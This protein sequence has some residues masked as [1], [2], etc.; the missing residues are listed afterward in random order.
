MAV[1]AAAIAIVSCSKEETAV[2]ATPIEGGIPVTIN[3]GSPVT[4]TMM[5]GS[6]PYWRDGDILG[7]SDGTSTNVQ[8]AENSIPDGE[9]AATATFSGKVSSAGT[10]YAYY[11]YTNN[12]V[13][14]SGAKVDIP[15]SQYPTATSFD[16]SADIMVSKSF[17][18]STTSATTINNL[19]FARLGAIVKIVLTDSESTMVGTQHPT[20]VSMT[21]AS[22]L[23]GRVYI[24]MVNQTIGEL[25]SGQSMTVTANYTAETKY[26][27]NGSNATYLIVYP[28]T[29]AEGSTLTIA[30]ST[31]DY[32]I[33]KNI[34]VPDGGIT[35]LPGKVNTLNISLKA[36]HITLD[37]SGD[38]LPFN[39]NMAWADNGASDSNTDIS[40]SI[41]SAE[42]S[43][44]LYTAGTKT[45][46]GKGGL[47]LGASSAS[48]SITTKELNLSGAFYI[49]I[50]SG[51]YGS[52]TGN[53]VV[54]VDGTNVISSG[55]MTGINNVNIAAGTFTKK[56]KVTIATSAKRGYLYSVN[57]VSG[58]H[59]QDPTLLVEPSPVNI[60]EGNTQQL[61]VTGTDGTIHYSSNNNSV[62]TVSSTGLVTAVAAGSTTISITSDATAN[63]NAGSTSVTINVTSAGPKTLPYQN[64]LISS[65]TD[66]SF[67]VVSAGGLGSIWSDSS[68]GMQ[69]NAYGCSSSV[70]AYAESPEIDLTSVAGAK[71]SFTHGINYFADVATAKTQ[72]TLEVKVKDGSWGA[73]TIPTYPASLGNSTANA[74]VDLS[75]YAGSIIQFRFKYLATTTNPGRW[76]IK[77]LSVTEATPPSITVATSAATATASAGGTTATLNGT[78]SLVNGAVIGSVTEAGFYYKLTSAGAYTK[79]T[80]ASAPATTTFSAEVTGLTTDAE[81]TYY[82]YAIYNGGSEV[83]GSTTTFTPTQ[84]GGG[85]SPTTYTSTLT[86]KSWASTGD[87][88]WTS[89]KE[90]AG[91]TNNGIQV[92]NNA[93]YT[94]ANG[95]TNKTFT[96]VSSV[97]VTYNTNK[98]AGNGT[99]DLKVGTNA[100]HTG[101]E[102]AYSGS[103]D[104]RTANFTATFDLSASPESGA[105]T[106]TANTTVNSIYIVSVTVTATAIS[107]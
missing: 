37:D 33:E 55:W 25:Y 39:D 60:V 78:I 75:T 27:I 100:A 72:A 10:Y 41:S 49:Q 23:V 101:L 76:Q 73:V 65:H 35:L 92:T 69:A 84:S 56:S 9:T 63:Y 19:R 5:S 58:T 8:F 62:A 106:L 59:V 98:S 68:Y 22:N 29:L 77:N 42:N 48:G 80:L 28:Q 24:D 14:A 12:G 61:T 81:Y 54:S 85:G 45:Y 94:G 93:L 30:A 57:I 34:T 31:E 67:N 44:G 16:G 21:A 87:F 70:E 46:K 2:P 104:G 52:D 6:T 99:L 74:E 20:T 88:G 107:N 50:E 1:A 71:L 15:V 32:S 95:T 82:A 51:K 102:W 17:T 66:F 103:S 4:M 36:S 47:K 89:G 86:S 64:T 91:F 79:K 90:G 18:I 96:N 3:T 38:A 83:T 105:I 53:L 7:V 26:A 97:V 13:G 40:A 11:P 43:S